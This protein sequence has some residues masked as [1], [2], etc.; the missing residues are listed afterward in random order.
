MSLWS[1]RSPFRAPSG[2]IFLPF[3][4]IFLPLSAPSG[5]LTNWSISLLSSSTTSIPYMEPSSVSKTIGAGA[6][7][8]LTCT[9]MSSPW[10]T[11][12]VY[13]YYMPF[14]NIR[15]FTL[16]CCK[17]FWLRHLV[18]GQRISSF[19]TNFYLMNSMNSL[20]PLTYSVENTVL[21]T[22]L[23]SICTM[24]WL[25]SIML[26]ISCGSLLVINQYLTTI[27]PINNSHDACMECVPCD[28]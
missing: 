4:T 8:T 5:S 1:L 21:C 14:N 13:V 19:S 23:L 22:Q 6:G 15:F 20:T 28:W 10:C 27:Y 25:Y 26:F 7:T 11:H 2:T 3:Y 24:S 12:R 16:G 17:Y 9:L 18:H